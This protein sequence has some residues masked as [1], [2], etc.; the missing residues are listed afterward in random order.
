MRNLNIKK[1]VFVIVFYFFLF[2]FLNVC[3]RIQPFKMTHFP[4]N[5]KSSSHGKDEI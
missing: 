1:N 3:H 5:G 2:S 4:L